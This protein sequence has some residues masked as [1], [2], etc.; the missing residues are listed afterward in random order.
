MCFLCRLSLVAMDRRR[1]MGTSPDASPAV[2]AMRLELW[3]NPQVAGS[4]TSSKTIADPARMQL[5][6]ET[7]EHRGNSALLTVMP[8]L[9]IAAE[10]TCPINGTGTA[11]P[12]NWPVLV[13]LKPASCQG[14]SAGV[15]PINLISSD[16]VVR[17]PRQLSHGPPWPPW[18]LSTSWQRPRPHSENSASSQCPHSLQ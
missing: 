12:N 5:A 10:S 17:L 14:T 6:Y 8:A 4:A 3:P 1:N 18:S 11:F 9:Y 16:V 2:M 15:N 7:E 13:E